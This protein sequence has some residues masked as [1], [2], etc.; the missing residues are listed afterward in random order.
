MVFRSNLLG[1]AS[2]QPTLRIPFALLLFETGLGLCPPEKK[3]KSRAA[4][5]SGYHFSGPVSPYDSQNWGHF[6]G[7]SKQYCGG[8]L[9]SRLVGGAGGIRTLGPVFERNLL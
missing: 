9:Q 5:C 6:L 7:F 2:H 1:S 3:D 4:P 8:S